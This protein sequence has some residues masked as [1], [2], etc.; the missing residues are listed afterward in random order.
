M[1]HRIQVTVDDR[2]NKAIVE[3]AKM[4]GLSISS[5]ARLAL[6][7]ALQPKANTLLEKAITDVKQGDL[8]SL[9]LN[10]FNKQLDNL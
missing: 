10:D 2:L 5:Y 1:S 9:S 6:M 8:Q 4:M 3:Q 7:S